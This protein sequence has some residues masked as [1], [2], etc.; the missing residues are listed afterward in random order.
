ML[1]IASIFK[2]TKFRSTHENKFERCCVGVNLPDQMLP[3]LLKKIQRW[4]GRATSPTHVLVN[5]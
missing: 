2:H 1:S 4:K 3:I 5:K